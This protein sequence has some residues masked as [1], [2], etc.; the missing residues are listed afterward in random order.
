MRWFCL[1]ALAIG[2][3]VLAM[4]AGSPG[5]DLPQGVDMGVYQPAPPVQ[6]AQ[7]SGQ[8]SLLGLAAAQ[9]PVETGIPSQPTPRDSFDKAQVA[10]IQSAQGGG[11]LT[12]FASA[13][14]QPHT[15]VIVEPRNKKI[16]VYQISPD[17]AT[18]LKSVRS[19]KW[20]LQMTEFNSREPLSPQAVREA[21]NR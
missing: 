11:I 16:L 1:G 17:G 9:T 12:H 5:E 15:L 7:V 19:F 21:I 4:P 8:A 3:L 2:T 10:G 18:A 6:S 20:D 14:G 13:P